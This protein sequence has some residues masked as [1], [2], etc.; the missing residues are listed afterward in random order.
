MLVGTLIFGCAAPWTPV[1]GQY[2]MGSENFTVNLPNGWQRYNAVANKVVITRQGML[3]QQIAIFRTPIDKKLPYTHKMILPDMLP[4]EVAEVVI[5]N[6]KSNP[7][8]S[9]G[10]IIEN[11]PALISGQ[12]GFKFVYNYRTKGGLDKKG[13]FYGLLKGDQLYKLVY[14]APRRY[15][16][17]KDLETFEDTVASF[18]LVKT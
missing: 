12:A 14:E 11:D 4:Q 10:V 8:I 3:L 1:S 17:D 5:D 7:N 2:D 15:Y 6:L 13:I 9:N 18:R 16:F